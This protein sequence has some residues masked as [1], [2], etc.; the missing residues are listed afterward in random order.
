VFRDL[1]ERLLGG[2]A[3]WNSFWEVIVF[4]CEGYVIATR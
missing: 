1:N 4:V 3:N 2:A